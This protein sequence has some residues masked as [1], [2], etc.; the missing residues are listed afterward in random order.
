MTH[1]DLRYFVIES[2]AALLF[3]TSVISLLLWLAVSA[4]DMPTVQESWSTKECVR[5]IGKGYS[6]DNLPAKYNHVWV[7]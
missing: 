1:T 5:V 6:C 4:S 2:A 3:V 7:E